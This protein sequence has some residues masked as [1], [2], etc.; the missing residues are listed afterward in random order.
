LKKIV[1]GEYLNDSL[2]DMKIKHMVLHLAQ[3]QRAFFHCF[4]CMFYARVTQVR[5]AKEGYELVSR[6]TKNVDLFQKDFILVPINYSFHWSLA[7]I[8]RPGLLLVCVTPSVT[9][10]PAVA[11]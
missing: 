4:S 11:R 7:I 10:K 8:V 1:D 2:I 9:S 5:N 6:W 3:E